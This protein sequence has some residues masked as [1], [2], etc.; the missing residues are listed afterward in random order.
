MENELKR[1]TKNLSVMVVEDT[2]IFLHILKNILSPFFSDIITAKDGS[3]AFKKYLSFYD[4]NHRYIDIVITD[5][6]MPK[7][8]GLELSKMIFKSNNKQEII[9]ISG[10]SDT[11]V[12]IQ[13]LNIGVHKFVTKPIKEELLLSVVYT[14]SKK[15]FMLHIQEEE[16]KEIQEHNKI[17]QEKELAQEKHLKEIYSALNESN[18]IARADKKGHIIYVNEQFCKI[19]GYTKDELIGKNFKK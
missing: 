3:E 16:Q 15:I 18:I 8:D 13:L 9:A 12:L 4:T 7:V 10:L 11:D 14:I 2:K 17:L 19:T 6:V 5:I 1:Y